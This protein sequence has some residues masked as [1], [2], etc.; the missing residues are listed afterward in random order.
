MPWVFALDHTHF[1]R[2]LSVHIRDTATL[3]ERHSDLL[4]EFQRGHF[5]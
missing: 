2:N 1:A 5:M 4:E 3:E